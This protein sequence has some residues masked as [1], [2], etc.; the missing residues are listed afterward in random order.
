VNFFATVI[1]ALAISTNVSEE[2]DT[3]T[4]NLYVQMPQGSTLNSSD[5]VARKVEER[6]EGL[7]EKQDVISKIYEDQSTVTIRLREDYKNIDN[8]TIEEIKDE[9]RERVDD[10]GEAEI[11]FDQPE[12]NRRF[13]G[14][15]G[16]NMGS[17]FARMIGVGA[18]T[19]TILVKGNDFEKMTKVAEDISYYLESLSSIDEANI[20]VSEDRPEVQL[21][22][23]QHLLSQYGISFNAIVSELSTFRNEFSSNTTFK[24]GIDE[25]DITI[26][27]NDS[28]DS[29]DKT[30]EDLRS[31]KISG[32]AG[33]M[34]D[35]EEISQ[36][37]FA[38]GMS[39]ISRVNQEKQIEITYRFFSEVNDS[40]ALLDQAKFDV[41]QLI[42][43]LIIPAGIAVEIVD[44]E[45][46]Y[47][48]YY[49]LIAVAILL[50]YMILASVFESLVTPFVL[51][52][53][54]PLAATGSLFALILS[55]NSLLNANTLTGFLILLG[56]VVNNGIILIDYS[57]ILKRKGFNNSR[58]LITAGLAR[59][60]PILIT[61]ITTIVA[62]IPLALGRAEY[63]TT[64][65]APFAITVIGGLTLS[66]VFTL[67]LI[68]TLHSDLHSSLE[69][70]RSMYWKI[71]LLQLIVFIFFTS[72]LIS[73]FTEIS[74]VF[75]CRKLVITK[76]VSPGI[77]IIT[78][79]K[80]AICQTKLSS[81]K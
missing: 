10:I 59:V 80:L 21:K 27:T 56:V 64:I 58:A 63:V 72:I 60:R 30:I 61:A 14:G 1:I 40:K 50:I 77:T 18:Q 71:K 15:A 57:N 26:R 37:V 81:L 16:S 34:H 66:T 62:M 20:S 78:K 17:R 46:V 75:A 8:R 29:E 47:Q 70:L 32:Q 39:S 38:G 53:S 28:L 2:V 48:E 36:I 52:F 3:D 42:S 76:Y 9:I 11:S 49:F 45:S 19:E 41:E 44:D 54:I 31:L 68:P 12:S 55:G 69:L 5:E 79:N 33:G 51:M 25:Y 67:I 65:G 7:N 13:R 23:D 73:S 35:I 43:S 4:F 74:F 22:F 24:Q 6:L